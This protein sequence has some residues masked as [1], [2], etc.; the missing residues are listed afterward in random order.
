MV[1]NRQLSPAKKIISA[2]YSYLS[3][4][5][6]LL[7]IDKKESMLLLIKRKVAT[8]VHSSIKVVSFSLKTFKEVST[9]KQMPNRLAEV[10]KICGAVLLFSAIEF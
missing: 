5:A 1:M 2:A 9:K 6:V 3:A 10:F 8:A 4:L 7:R